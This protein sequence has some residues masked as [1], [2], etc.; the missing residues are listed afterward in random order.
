MQDEPIV[1][2]IPSP[3]PAVVRAAVVHQRACALIEK[4]GLSVEA[5]EW[6]PNPP[7]SRLPP[8]NVMRVEKP[9][10]MRVRHA[11]H[12]CHTTFG[13]AKNCRTC[14]HRRCVECPR[15]PAKRMHDDDKEN[16]SSPDSDGDDD[17]ERRDKRMR[18]VNSREGS[19]AAH[20]QGKSRSASSGPQPVVQM[21][22]ARRVCHQCQQ[23]FPSGTAQVCVSCGHLRCSKCPRE[24]TSLVW[25]GGEEGGKVAT[26]P[27]RRPDRVYRRPRQRIRWICDHCSSVFAEGSKVCGECLHKR[28]GFCTRLP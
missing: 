2:A 28:C 27:T 23:D 3:T 5:H 20:P 25:P 21:Q 17:S 24:L 18:K 7:S 1:D 16:K 10:R 9:I 13:A 6:T 26:E 15:T 14:Q 19:P 11:C 4:Y 22:Q 8:S 12:L